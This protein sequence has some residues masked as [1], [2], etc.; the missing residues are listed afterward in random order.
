M[1]PIRSA[2]SRRRVAAAANREIGTGYSTVT[3]WIGG[4]VGGSGPSW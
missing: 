1:P 2:I 3:P 4:P